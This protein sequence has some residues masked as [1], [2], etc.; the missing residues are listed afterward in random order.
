MKINKAFFYLL[1]A[2][3]PLMGGEDVSE[4]KRLNLSGFSIEFGYSARSFDGLMLS[5]DS[6]SRNYNS[7]KL[8]G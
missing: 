8:T 5:V 6:F 1:L 3:S 7:T 2:V 4:N